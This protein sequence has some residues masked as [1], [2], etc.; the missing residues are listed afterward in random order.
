MTPYFGYVRVS[1]RKQKAGVSLDVQKSDI[2]R[3]A[4]QR[5]FQI[6]D[7]FVE[8]QTAAK[9]GRAVFSGMLSRLEKGEARGVIIHKIDRSARNLD[10]WNMLSK[11][12]DRGIDF[13]FAHEPIDLSTRGGRLSADMLAVVAA[14]FI[15]NNRQEARKGFYGRLQQG[16]YPLPAPIGYL[17]KGKGNPKAIDPARA[18]VIRQAF[19]LYASNTYGL[20]GLRKEMKK[21][22]LRSKGGKVLSLNAL[23]WV[24]HNPF[25]IGLIH[26]KKTGETFKGK[27]EPLVTKAMFDRV[28]AILAGKTA[29][30]SVKHDFVFRRLI[31]CSKCGFHLIGE[32]QKSQYV[33]YRCHS[34][35]CQGTNIR[36]IEI[37]DVL[38]K[39]LRLLVSDEAELR[40]FGDLV[41][42]E[43]KHIDEEVGKL[44]ASFD[45]R[46]AK[47][48][49]RLSRLTDAY[50]DQMID[51]DTFEA[52]KLSLW[53]EQRTLLDQRSAISAS[54]LPRAK[55]LKKLE[56]GTAA[57]SG[58]IS[59]NTFERREI[60]G[61]VTSNL[62]A[63]GNKPV[64]ALKSPYQEIVNWRKSQNCAPRRGT[65]RERAKELLDI[66]LAVDQSSSSA[67]VKP[68]KA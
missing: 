2:E 66:I 12:Y 32:R 67:A 68:K 14:D 35:G 40:E 46:I 49:E 6:V 1:D 58:Y 59:A 34:E 21:R 28:Q 5:G 52:R 33:Y 29:L 24:L 39:L 60:I 16:I 38:Q 48:D 23:S 37:D 19:E 3:F 54:E 63:E 31:A 7:W 8:V 56:L 30:R 15:R 50:I 25:Y 47:C 20:V 13:Q 17:D 64:I 36:E 62:G 43:R 22:G 42:V 57:Y 10:D 27:H 53:G 26:L 4:A 51:K 45:L 41:E 18:P 11:L 44:S 65:P 55:A 9:A 61:Q